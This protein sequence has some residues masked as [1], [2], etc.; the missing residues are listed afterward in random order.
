MNAPVP[1]T[2]DALPEPEPRQPTSLGRHYLRYLSASV[3]SVVAG[4]ISYPIMTRLLPRSEIGLITLFGP[5]ALIWTAVLKM[6][7]QNSIQRFYPIHCLGQTTLEK[8]RSYYASLVQMP[9]LISAV[10]CALAIGATMLV[11]AFI[12]IPNARYLY[13]VLLLGE[14]GVLFSLIDNIIRAREH[15]ALSSRLSV[16]MRYLQLV[17]FV[18]VVAAISPTAMGVYL[19]KLACA[20]VFLLIAGA[21][22]VRHCDF[23]L[24][25]FSPRIFRESLGYGLP[26]VL[27][28]ISFILLAFAD[29]M[30]FAMPRY[31]I[32]LDQVGVF[33][34][35]YDLAMYIGDFLA[36][37]LIPAF[38]P[39]A[40]RVYETEGQAAALALQ[41]Q[42]LHILYYVAAAITVGLIF[43]GPDLLIVCAHPKN[44][45]SAPI[46]QWIGINYVFYP[47]F[48]VMAYGL[49]LKK[50]TKVISA[51]VL[52]SAAV[53]IALNCWLL[54]RLGIM[55][56][57][58]ATLASYLL[59]G[60]LQMVF[61]P[62]GCLPTPRAGDLARPL[63][64]AALM[65]AVAALGLGLGGWSGLVGSHNHFVRLA[66]MAAI[67]AVTFVAPALALDGELRRK[68]GAK[69]G[70]LRA[71][72]T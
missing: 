33:G 44:A 24:R 13:I 1:Q 38:L 68:L 45:P 43:V 35:G 20:F 66:L 62:K 27:S 54:P 52:A 63:G 21:W 17:F 48:I 72:M 29:R 6:G 47:I 5:F 71:W 8:R 41:R 31:R 34:I 61:C 28:E 64:L 11:G 16:M 40:N 7:T 36:Y 50:R 3:L 57:V 4:F 26:L 18:V 55:G 67:F 65:T 19:A 59:M 46:F 23:D 37:S 60:V 51:V 25:S 49:N 42:L 53:N 58:Y 56:A 30:M 70:F 39:V 32:S 69:L 22:A 9:A 12:P 2:Q 14:F 10:L 15:S